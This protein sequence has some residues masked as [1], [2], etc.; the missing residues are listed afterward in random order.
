MKYMFGQKGLKLRKTL[1][2]R[3]ILLIT[4]NFLAQFFLASNIRLLRLEVVIGK[5]DKYNVLNLEEH[6]NKLESMINELS[7]AMSGVKHEQEYMEVRERIHR[8][9]RFIKFLFQTNLLKDILSFTQIYQHRFVLN[10]I[11]TKK[12]ILNVHRKKF[13]KNLC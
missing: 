10:F 4:V 11:T 2:K 13:A 9:S 6:H 12:N 5:R 1:F 8:A 3:A 7:I